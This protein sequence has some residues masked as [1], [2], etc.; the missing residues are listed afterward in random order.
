MGTAGTGRATEKEETSTRLCDQDVLRAK[1]LLLQTLGK[2]TER[3]RILPPP[4]DMA[5]LSV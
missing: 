4:E 3:L 1:G 5:K 2:Q